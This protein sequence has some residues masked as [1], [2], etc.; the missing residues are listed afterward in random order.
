[1]TIEQ[2]KQNVETA[3]ASLAEAEQA[4]AA[5]ESAPEQNVFA[6]LD[7][8]EGVLQERMEGFAFEDCQGAHNRGEDQYEQE[9]IVAGVHY[10]ATLDCEYNR[11]D[12]TYYYLE[13]SEF[14]YKKLEV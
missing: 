8:A 5:F 10:L 4:L 14:S 3:K 1:M 11:H 13:E 7:E 2:L 12:K 9:F 6:S